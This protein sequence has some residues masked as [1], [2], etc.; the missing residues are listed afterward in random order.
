MMSGAALVLYGLYIAAV[1]YHDN[2]PTLLSALP[3]A[4][5]YFLWMIVILILALAASIPA[6]E[7]VVI[8]IAIL[9]GLAYL[10]STWPTISQDGSNFLTTFGL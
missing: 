3:E 5:G 8:G 10:L 7:P 2:L 4:K 1:T 6:I 9:I